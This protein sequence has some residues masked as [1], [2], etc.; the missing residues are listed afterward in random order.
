MVTELTGVLR[1]HHRRPAYTCRVCGL[2][3]L[4]RQAWADHTWTHAPGYGD[5]VIRD[6]YVVIR[7]KL[8]AWLAGDPNPHHPDC[9]ARHGL[10][11]RCL[12]HGKI[13]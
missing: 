6:L 8:A 7:A 5:A 1:W 10:A 3:L 2:V 12:G 9:P 11:C 13:H 4:E